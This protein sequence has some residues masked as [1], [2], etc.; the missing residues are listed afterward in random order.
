MYDVQVTHVR[1]LSP[2]LLA[3]ITGGRAG[4]SCRPAR[5]VVWDSRMVEPG[6]AFFALPGSTRDGEE[7]VADALERGAALAF[8]R[9][10]GPRRLTVGDTYAALLELGRWLRGGLAGPLLAVTGSVGK[11]STKEALRQVLGW[12]A[13]PGNLNTP[14]ALARFFWNLDPAAAGAVVELGIDHPGEMDDLVYLTRPDLGILTAIAPVHLEGLGTLA[15]VAR[16]KMRLLEAATLKLAHVA[17]SSWGLPAGSRTYGFEAGADFRGAGL[18]LSCRG[19]SFTYG[20]R[21]LRLQTLGRGAALAAL[22]ALAAAELL[23]EDVSAAADKLEQQAPAP[24]R[25]QPRRLGDALWLDDSYNA[26]PRALEAALELL[27]RC[28]GPKGVILGTMRELGAEGERWHRWAAARVREVAERALFIG[29]FA[30]LMAAGWPAASASTSVSEAAELLDDWRR[31]LRTVLL[32]GSRALEL[33][34]LLEVP[35]A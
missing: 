7:F 30:P 31:G 26:S 15:D 17:T 8:S 21:R 34:K 23:G 13:T 10:G 22:A 6:Y 33:E 25:L 16:E 18:E 14:P 24:H 11:T 29:E 1:T 35:F 4:E 12:P 27:S 28:P 9:Q 32:K 20:G 3:A 5:D 2:D 19:T